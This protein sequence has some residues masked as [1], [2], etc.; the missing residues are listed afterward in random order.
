MGARPRVLPLPE[1]VDLGEW[2]IEEAAGDGRL[3]HTVLRVDEG[4]GGALIVPLDGGRRERYI[5]A[6]ELGHAAW[7][8]RGRSP[9]HIPETT[10]QHAED[11]R[12]GRRLG[13]VGIRAQVRLLSD[14]EIEG[15]AR[16][17]ADRT[18]ARVE[19]ASMLLATLEVP[20][21][22]VLARA[23]ARVDPAMP[24]LVARVW[25]GTVGREAKPDFRRAVEAAEMLLRLFGRP[26]GS[27]EDAAAPDAMVATKLR[28]GALGDDGEG[29]PGWGELAIVEPP[30]LLRLPPRLAGACWRADV[31]GSRLG[32]P[33]RFHRDGRGWRTRRRTRHAGG[34]V[35]I[36]CSGSMSLTAGMLEEL[37]TANPAALIATYSGDDDQERGRL[38]IV[39]RRGS[40]VHPDRVRPPG[41]YN[42]CDG[43]AL[44]WL[45]RHPEPR[46]WVSDG[47]VTGRGETSS[48]KLRA[49]AANRMRRHRITRVETAEALIREWRGTRPRRGR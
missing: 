23:V 31:E 3:A 4:R 32:D 15:M 11:A 34:S 33:S 27:D 30:R 21:G 44:D 17:L 38:H 43:P 18:L 1:A 22:K 5:R 24:R 29:H 7:S 28:A 47:G 2:M 35:L 25:A 8:P 13:A 20:D 40:R 16:S 9:A 10:M 36:D 39:A 42:V 14:D 49:D 26:E 37:V 41:I 46:I 48:A 12:I 6:H 19:V 45:G